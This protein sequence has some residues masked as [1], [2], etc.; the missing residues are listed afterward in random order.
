MDHLRY[1][2]EVRDMVAVL[3]A[4]IHPGL[5]ESSAGE[6][7]RTLNRTELDLLTSTLFDRTMGQDQLRYGRIFDCL[8]HWANLQANDFVM[9]ALRLYS[10]TLLLHGYVRRWHWNHK[11]QFDSLILI[12]NFAVSAAFCV[13]HDRECAA[14]FVDW[15]SRRTRIRP[16]QIVVSSATAL[17]LARS[18]GGLAS[19]RSSCSALSEYLGEFDTDDSNR[20]IVALRSMLH[21][22][23][24]ASRDGQ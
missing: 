20:T 13:E 16:W 23:I 8:D 19:V 12:S 21:A 7:S 5:L 24:A 11:N 15:F 22:L 6:V 4:T 17:L 3:A 9:H 10:T 2:R 18:D 1:P 14:A